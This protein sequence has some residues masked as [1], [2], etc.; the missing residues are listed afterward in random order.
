MTLDELNAITQKEKAGRK[1]TCVRT[2]MSTGCMSSGA[3]EIKKALDKEVA[4]K[5][6]VGKVEVRRVGC[7][8]LCGGGPLVTV[9]PGNKIYQHVTPETAPSIIDT[10]LGGEAIPKEGDPNSPFYTRQT[11]VVRA[12]AGRIDPERIEDYIEAGGYQAL[13]RALYEMNPHQI[14]EAVNKSGLRGRGG[15]GFPTG[16]KWA[17]VAKAPGDLKYIV[18]NGDE[19]DPGAFMDSSILESSPHSVLE[20]MAIAAFAVGASEGFLYVRAEY[21]LAI[22]RLQTAIRQAKA[23]GLLGSHIF[24]STFSFNVEIRIGAGAFV[25]GEETALMASIEGGRGQPRPRPPFPAEKGL[26]GKPTLINNV[27]TFANIA[28]IIE[29]GAD[30]Y[31]SK[32]TE[33]SKGTKVFSLTGNVR[34][35]GLIEVPMGITIREIVEDLGGGATEGRTIKAVQTGGPSGGCIPASLF[36]TAVDY[37]SLMAVGSIMG[38][39]GMVV[40]DDHTNMVELAKFYMEFCV[41]ESCG[42]CIPCRAGTVQ[43]AHLL[44]KILERKGTPADVEQLEELCEMVKNTSLCGLGQTAPNPV[45]STLR[46]FRNEYL[47][48]LQEEK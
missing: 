5:G 40:L 19:G 48:L 2:C 1:E 41:E 45:L 38:S 33:K 39:G 43:I 4:E 28:P 30:W 46:Y 12:N 29:H 37:N 9:E 16:I 13:H 14:V 34:N 22:S 44:T 18:C 32:G 7:M 15:A 25:C 42:K 10:F 31:A 23:K 24:E 20:G 3:G 8:G 17:T 6:L 26:W 11:S 35:N 27:E 47:A 36:D 21:P